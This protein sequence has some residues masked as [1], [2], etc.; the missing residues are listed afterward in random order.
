MRHIFVDTSAWYALINDADA[1]HRRAKSYYLSLIKRRTALVTSSDVLTESYTRLR[2][3]VG[4]RF[5]VRFHGMMEMA[6][7]QG[8]L[9]VVWV[10]E[11]IASEAWDIFE[12]YEDQF[13]SFQDCTSF[14]IARRLDIR[15]VFAFDED[16][17][18]MGFRVWP[19][20]SNQRASAAVVETSKEM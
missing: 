14:V 8:I 15:D 18:V 1:N 7:R 5:A 10:D 19:G 11:D 16:F 6:Q 3:S 20:H 9:R 2:Y 13:F 17:G 12:R 4:H